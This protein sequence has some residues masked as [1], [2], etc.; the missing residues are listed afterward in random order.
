MV[1][2]RAEEMNPYDMNTEHFLENM[3]Q[4]F[5]DNQNLY[6][7]KKFFS[8]EAVIQLWWGCR[9]GKNQDECFFDSNYMRRCTNN[10]EPCEKVVVVQYF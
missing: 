5:T 7:I 1:C 3:D 6:N 4:L 10:L 8:N 2:F 9:D